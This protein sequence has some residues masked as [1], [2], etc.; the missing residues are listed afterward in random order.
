MIRYEPPNG[1][2]G[3]A[4]SAV[5]GAQ[6]LALAA[7][8]DDHEDL[9]LGRDADDRSSIGDPGCSVDELAA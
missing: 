2:A 6:A 8:E 5:S 4:R 9:G 7:G 1:T 3:L